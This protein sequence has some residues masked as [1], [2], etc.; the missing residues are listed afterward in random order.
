[1]NGHDDRG[2]QG[3]PDYPRS[4]P[5][6]IP[7]QGRGGD[8]RAP[9]WIWVGNRDGVRRATVTLPGP[10]TILLAL[11]LVA[12]VVGVILVVVLGAVLLWIPVVIVL[13]GAL[14]LSAAVRRH[15]LRFRHWVSRR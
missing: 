2:R 8:S 7:P 12:L 4:E 13:I 9:V 5:E 15:W 14:L 11:A 10:F 3:P 6:I 1:M